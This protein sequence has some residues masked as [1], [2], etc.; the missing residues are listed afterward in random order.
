MRKHFFIAANS[1]VFE[2]FTFCDL[3]RLAI[4]MSTHVQ[5]GSV[6]FF[7][8]WIIDNRADGPAVFDQEQPKS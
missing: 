6:K 1:A 2:G 4:T 3:N 7:M 5:H 8:S